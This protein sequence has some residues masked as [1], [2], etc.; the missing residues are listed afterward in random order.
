MLKLYLFIVINLKFI[1]R[2]CYKYL[3]TKKG[4]NILKVWFLRILTC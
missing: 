3:K 2:Y 4:Y 1:I